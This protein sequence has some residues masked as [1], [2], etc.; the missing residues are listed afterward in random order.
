MIERTKQ[1][2]NEW[3]IEL[4][5]ERRADEQTNQRTSKITKN[6]RDRQTDKRTNGRMKY[7]PKCYL[8][9]II[10]TSF[11][12]RTPEYALMICNIRTIYSFEQRIK[13]VY[14][15]RLTYNLIQYNRRAYLKTA[16]A[17][18]QGRLKEIKVNIQNH[19]L[20]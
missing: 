3:T 17:V 18:I 1:R 20:G 11:K 15:V 7:V 19:P 6:R 5:N 13:N 2:A 8:I 4:A 9:E 14:L 10:L 12:P 16:E